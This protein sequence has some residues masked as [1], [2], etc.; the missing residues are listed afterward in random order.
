MV[1]LIRCDQS[2]ADRLDRRGAYNP[3][4]FGRGAVL[5]TGAE[6]TEARRRGDWE[7]AEPHLALMIEEDAQEIRWLGRAQGGRV[8]TD[9]DRIVK[10]SEIQEISRLPISVMQLTLPPRHQDVMSR[11]G[12]LPPAG[13]AAVISA[14]KDLRPEEVDLIDY[15]QRPLGVR[16]PAGPRG[17]LLNQERDGLGLLLDIAGVGRQSFLQSWSP[18]RADVPFLAGIPDRAEL[19]DHLIAHD[20]ERFSSW[21]PSATSQLAWRVFSNGRRRMFIMNANRTAIEHTLGVDVV[22]WNEDEGAFVLVQY[23]KMKRDRDGAADNAKLLAYRPD[24]NLESELERMRRVDEMCLEN[25][26]D[27]RLSA[28]PCWVKLCDPQPRLQNPSELI[29]GMY[30]ARAHFE[31]LLETCKGPRS[32]AFGV[33]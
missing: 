27:F 30:L 15:L 6:F 16:L 5:G 24:H 17:E 8:I 21:F 28:A 2:V 22:Y 7:G 31:K 19:E 14:L 33:R 4:F 18:T 20:I 29:R 25:V 9:R 3:S 32:P 12:I 13:G 11:N 10:V 1:A 26:G 23:K